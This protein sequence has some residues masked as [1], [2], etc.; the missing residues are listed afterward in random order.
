[1][2]LRFH[3]VEHDILTS[4]SVILAKQ[5]NFLLLLGFRANIEIHEDMV[6]LKNFKIQISTWSLDW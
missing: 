5:A 3:N 1:M 4:F 6:V 2:V